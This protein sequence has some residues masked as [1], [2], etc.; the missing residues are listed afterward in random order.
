MSLEVHIVV[1]HADDD[2]R[3]M[4]LLHGTGDDENDLVPLCRTVCPRATIRIGQSA[5]RHLLAFGVLALNR[6]LVRFEDPTASAPRL[7][8]R[9]R[10]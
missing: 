8:L 6:H 4:L 2:A 5:V 7:R 1:A 3:P 10:H 9:R